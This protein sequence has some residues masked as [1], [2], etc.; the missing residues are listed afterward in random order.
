MRRT[1]SSG[2]TASVQMKSESCRRCASSS[3]CC[4][5]ELVARQCWAQACNMLLCMHLGKCKDSCKPCKDICTPCNY[6]VSS[7]RASAAWSFAVA[8]ALHLSAFGLCKL[9]TCPASRRSVMRSNSFLRSGS[10]CYTCSQRMMS[11]SCRRSRTG[12]AYSSCWQ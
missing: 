1:D 8:K 10:G 9:T 4:C 11:S 3:S 7:R 5:D 12:S 2:R 6:A